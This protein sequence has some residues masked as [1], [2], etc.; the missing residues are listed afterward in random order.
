MLW[1]SVVI[2]YIVLGIAGAFLLHSNSSKYVVQL[3]STFFAIWI[4]Q[5]FRGY[6]Y[7]FLMDAVQDYYMMIFLTLVVNA[8][9]CGFTLIF[10]RALLFIFKQNNNER[11]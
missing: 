5:S 7:P 10:T 3:V 9:I 2:A 6:F 4:V 11:Y 8:V 1:I